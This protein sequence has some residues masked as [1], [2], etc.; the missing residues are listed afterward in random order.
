MMQIMPHPSPLHT[1]LQSNIDFKGPDECWNWTASV[2]R[3][4]YGRI[5]A[6]GTQM[7]AHRAAYRF[8]VGEIPDGLFVCHRCDNRRC[9]NPAHMFLGTP[10]DNHRDCIA[11]GRRVT[12]PARGEASGLAKLTEAAVREIRATPAGRRNSRRL[13]DKYGVTVQYL[14]RIRNRERWAHVLD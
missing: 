7:G 5:R 9:C 1:R 3:D 14:L 8:W 10:L 2:F 11:K 4:G 13:A 6:F 12:R